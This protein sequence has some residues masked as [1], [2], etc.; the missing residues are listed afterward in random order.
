[1]DVR[2]TERLRNYERKKLAQE[3]RKRIQKFTP[4]P[5]NR[6]HDCRGEVV[7]KVTGLLRG[8][9]EYSFPECNKCGRVY[10]YAKDVRTVGEQ[11]FLDR[12]NKPYSMQ[13]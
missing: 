2:N 9:F 13:G 6:C 5:N 3:I 12:L 7:R 1:M 8:K 11:E 10:C 4:L